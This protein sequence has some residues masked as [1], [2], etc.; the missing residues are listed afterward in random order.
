MSW[1]QPVTNNAVMPSTLAVR[2]RVNRMPMGVRVPGVL[3]R[4]LRNEIRVKSSEEPFRFDPFEHRI[5]RLDAQEEFVTT[6]TGKTIDV[7]HRVI[8]HRQ[9]IQRE[10]AEHAR[11]RREQ[12]RQFKARTHKS[13]P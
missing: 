10:H 5:R 4:H 7:E 9:T 11:K 13:R 3:M 8:W 6:G 1:R 12:D 2:T